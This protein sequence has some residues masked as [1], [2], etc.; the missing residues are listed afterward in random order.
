MLIRTQAACLIHK[1]LKF[2]GG[3]DAKKEF[4]SQKRKGDHLLNGR[5]QA[6]VWRWTISRDS[7]LLQ[8]HLWLTYE[9]MA[10]VLHLRFPISQQNCVGLGHR[11][12]VLYAWTLA[13]FLCFLQVVT[14]SLELLLA[15]RFTLRK[16]FSGCLFRAY[17]WKIVHLVPAPQ[18]WIEARGWQQ[19][20]L[21]VDNKFSVMTVSVCNAINNSINIVIMAL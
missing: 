16:K 13:H 9:E 1:E 8:G 14:P 20:E 3:E 2:Y 21:A 11:C 19:H 10:Q 4:H 15:I 18:L 6:R 12:H 17:F 7:A 5:A